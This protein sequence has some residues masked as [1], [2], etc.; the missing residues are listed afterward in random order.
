M[1]KHVMHDDKRWRV[2]RTTEIDDAPG[3][4]LERRQ[5]FTGKTET[6]YAR[7]ADCQSDQHERVRTIRDEDAVLRYNVTRGIVTLS[8]P[9]SRAKIQC[10][11]GGLLA[12]AL[13]QR[14]INLKRD[15]DFKRR[16]RSR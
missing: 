8:A 6:V 11:L 3:Y 10:T 13:R 16:T 1:S 15:R 7:V 2:A 12:M 9:R 5:P 4:V 14:A